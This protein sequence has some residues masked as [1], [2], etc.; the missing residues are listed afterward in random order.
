M[1][2]TGKLT[3][4]DALH[5]RALFLAKREIAAQ[6]VLWG[7]RTVTALTAW[8]LLE[9]GAS[10]TAVARW[11]RATESIIERIT[12]EL[13]AAIAKGDSLAAI[14]RTRLDKL[15]AEMGE[16]DTRPPLPP[17]HSAAIFLFPVRERTRRQHVGSG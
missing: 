1:K 12:G 2:I 11:M 7:D 15:A 4:N 9:A 3:N 17:G 8:L 16:I 10:L 14:A 13:D 5:R 6:P